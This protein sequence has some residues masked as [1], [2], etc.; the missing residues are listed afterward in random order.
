VCLCSVSLVLTL[1][2]LGNYKA[3]GQIPPTYGYGYGGSTVEF[4]Y[5]EYYIAE[6]AG[7]V[8]IRVTLSAPSSQTVTVDYSTSDGTATAPTDYQSAS[9]TLTFSPGQT[10]AAFQV[11]TVLSVISL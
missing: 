5:G 9:G 1:L 8:T 10:S 6:D 11:I 2:Y 7:S 3:L 4:A